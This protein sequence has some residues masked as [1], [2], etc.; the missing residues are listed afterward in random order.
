[1]K[2]N[3]TNKLFGFGASNPRTKLNENQDTGHSHNYIL[4]D[5][6]YIQTKSKTVDLKQNDEKMSI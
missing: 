4:C 1:M 6:N 3:V 2:K 5:I